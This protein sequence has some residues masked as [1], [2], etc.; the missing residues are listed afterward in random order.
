MLRG[1]W[2]IR[3]TLIYKGRLGVM[4]V[5][6]QVL[7][8]VI[9][10][11]SGVTEGRLRFMQSSVWPCWS[12]VTSKCLSEITQ[13]PLLWLQALRVQLSVNP[14]TICYPIGDRESLIHVYACIHAQCFSQAF[15]PAVQKM[16]QTVTLSLILSDSDQTA[17]YWV[18][19]FPI[20]LRV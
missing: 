5:K 4:L 9:F 11:S 7:R 18:R 19:S 12:S 10:L 15:S 2:F 1:V 16:Y 20:R 13:L 8:S 3:G 6:D 17:S 14:E